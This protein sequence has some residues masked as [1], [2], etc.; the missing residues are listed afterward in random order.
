M[1]FDWREY[2]TLAQWLEANTPPGMSQEAAQRCAI[3][4]AYFAAYGYAL[5]YATQYLGFTPRN[6]SEDHGRL[7]DHL[8]RSRRRKTAES[9]D[10]LREWRNSSD[11]DG[12]FPGDLA[13][14]LANALSEA[15]YVFNSL[16]PPPPRPSPP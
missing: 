7:R 11:Y 3:S 10:R 2:L 16:P 15:E 12:D 6:A 9:L 4:R 14:T 8:K 5:N 1:A 13:A